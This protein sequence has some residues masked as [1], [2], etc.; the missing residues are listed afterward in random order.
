M[1]TREQLDKAVS[2]AGSALFTV[3]KLMSDMGRF[4]SLGDRARRLACAVQLNEQALTIARACN[5]L[6][7]FVSPHANDARYAKQQADALAYDVVR[8]QAAISPDMRIADI[9]VIIE[10]GTRS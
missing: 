5:V 8:K 1:T 2:E 3:R 4:V 6:G 10:K 7:E 9:V